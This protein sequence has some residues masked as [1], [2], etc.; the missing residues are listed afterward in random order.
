MVSNSKSGV[1]ILVQGARTSCNSPA[2]QQAARTK[3]ARTLGTIL[4]SAD[5]GA[6]I[7]RTMAPFSMFF[8]NKPKFEPLNASVTS[9]I[10]NGLRRS[11]LSLPY[12]AIASS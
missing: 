1:A 7:A 6:G 9:E 4:S 2:E 12:F 8:A 3:R 10:S 11:G 5:F